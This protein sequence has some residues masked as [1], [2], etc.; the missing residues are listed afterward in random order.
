MLIS[1]QC[2]VFWPYFLNANNCWHINPIA[3][4]NDQS[5]FHVHER[6]FIISGPDQIAPSG[7]V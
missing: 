4:I 3:Q 1:R 2:H 6:C 7:A 5:K